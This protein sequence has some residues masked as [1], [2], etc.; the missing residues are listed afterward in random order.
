ME[1]SLPAPRV[2]NPPVKTANLP[3]SPQ[4]N[5]EEEATEGE[6]YNWRFVTEEV[7]GQL[8]YEYA[9]EFAK[10][11]KEKSDGRINIEVYEFGGLGDEVNQVEQ[12][13]AGAVE[14]AIVSPGFTGTM[15]KEGQVFALHY[16]FPTD[17][18]LVREILDS[19]KALN[20]DLAAQYEQH[21]IKVL[22]YWTEGAMAWTADRA[23]QTPA[24]SRTLR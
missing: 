18:E 6:T 2:K 21:N 1:S 3:V 13:Q 23:L 11:L 22:D 7:D 20:E 9:E 16:L 15:V 12:L 14:F 8:Q 10:R 4:G 19:S 17:Q 5:T 24:I